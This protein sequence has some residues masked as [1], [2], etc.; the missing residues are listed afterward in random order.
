M[1]APE[2]I[3]SYI[4]Q[5]RQLVDNDDLVAR[6]R[7]LIVDVAVQLFRERGYHNASTRD[8]AKAAGMSVG[9]LYQYIRHKEDIMVLILQST[10]TKQ[11]EKMLPL[12]KQDGDSWAVLA[13]C[14]D[15]YYRI[16]EEDYKK[17]QLVYYYSGM[18]DLNTRKIF[19]DAEKR[20]HNIWRGIIESGIRNGTFACDEV[21]F[22]AH[23]IV[24]MGHMWALK[25]G[26]F[27]DALTISKYIELELNMLENLLRSTHTTCMSVTGNSSRKF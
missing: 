21:D 22:Y 12:L 16:L 27:K 14:V 17:T 2:T 1:T 18:L 5:I 9:G 10:I 20:I 19:V 8:I 25:R 4:D 24:S 7:Q 3:E 11:E 13:S 15:A 6:N 26:R 23:N